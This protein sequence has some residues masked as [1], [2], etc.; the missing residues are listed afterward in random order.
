[1]GV[2]RQGFSD[3]KLF[4]CRLVTDAHCDYSVAAVVVVVVLPVALSV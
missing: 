2:L 3:E 4:G 1:M